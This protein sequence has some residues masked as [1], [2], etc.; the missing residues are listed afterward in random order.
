MGFFQSPL[1][2]TPSSLTRSLTLSVHD[3]LENTAKINCIENKVQQ[4]G[5]VKSISDVEYCISEWLTLLW[6]QFPLVWSLVHHCNAFCVSVDLNYIYN[7]EKVYLKYNIPFIIYI[8]KDTSS[9]AIQ[10]NK[11]IGLWELW[12]IMTLC[13]C[14]HGPDLC[15]LITTSHKPIVNNVKSISSSRSIVLRSN[16]QRTTQ[17]FNNERPALICPKNYQ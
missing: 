10:P 13:Q 9:V 2:S 16:V 3:Q 1:K 14:H 4:R 12:S 11:I 6:L 8:P 5:L 15:Y 7:L 17:A